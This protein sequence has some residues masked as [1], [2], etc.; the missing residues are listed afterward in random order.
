MSSISLLLCLLSFLDFF[1]AEEQRVLAKLL[2]LSDVIQLIIVILLIILLWK[3]R[4][5]F[6]WKYYLICATGVLF[7]INIP[8]GL[9]IDGKAIK[10]LRLFRIIE[11]C[12]LVSLICTIF[13][14][15]QQLMEEA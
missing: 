3:F 4:V 9:F 8:Y 5:R 12:V 2:R 7:F 10:L 6:P 14:V 11:P 13:K 15:R 1:I